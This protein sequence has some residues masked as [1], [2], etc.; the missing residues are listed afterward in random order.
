MLA[1]PKARLTAVGGDSQYHYAHYVL[2]YD[3]TIA[4]ISIE[5]DGP[6]PTDKGDT[7]YTRM[8]HQ[9]GVAALKAAVKRPA[10]QAYRRAAR[11]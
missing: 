8:L 11:R 9:L 1:E 4:R 5:I 7:A 6:E 10:A 3:G 2:E